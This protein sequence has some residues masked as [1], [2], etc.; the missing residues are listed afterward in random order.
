MHL[1]R[2]KPPNFT[3]PK[4]HPVVQEAYLYTRTRLANQAM[5]PP[6]RFLYTGDKFG[7]AR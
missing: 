4:N 2:G 7:A 1:A 3:R 5:Y 6:S